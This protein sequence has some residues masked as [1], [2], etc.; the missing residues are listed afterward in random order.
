M[1][2][3]QIA[4]MGAN[5]AIDILIRKAKEKGYE[6]HVFAWECGDPGEKSADFFYPVSVDN[7]EKILE[8][9]KGLNLAGVASITSDFTV[10]TVNFVARN[11]GLVCNS[12]KT[13]AL[14]RN[15]FL[16]RCAFKEAGLYTPW[17]AK[18][19]KKT[20][21]QFM[22]NH[23][24]P[25]IVKPTDRWSSKGVTRVDSFAEL[26]A[27]VDYAVSESL[28]GEAIIEDFMKGPEYSAE[29]ICQDGVCHILAYTEKTTTGH[30]HFVETGHKE[31]AYI[32]EHLKAYTNDVI[33]R[34][35][36]ALDI[37][38]GAAHVEFRIIN[39]KEIGIIEIGAR[40]GGDY[41]G[42]DLVRLST[43]FDYVGMVVDVACGEKLSFNASEHYNQAF[44]RFILEKTDIVELEIIKNSSEYIIERTVLLGRDFTHEVLNSSD[45][46]GYFIYKAAIEHG[47]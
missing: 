8:I 5:E 37:K 20:K 19:D 26:K 39:N 44:V 6:T 43:G 47:S 11:L 33:K 25:V 30:P 28:K 7:K 2:K 4:I 31:P 18:A 3:P 36:A 12:E 40:M 34:A 21:L 22:K 24:Y 13:D 9:C 16:M 17:F 10:N 32:P 46:L 15:K 29:C 35:V 1:K 41:I 14:A 45:R 38:N 23:D 42:T 27:A